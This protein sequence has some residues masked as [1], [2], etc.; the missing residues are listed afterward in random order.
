MKP[1]LQIDE[2]SLPNVYACGDVADT[3]VQTPNAR[4]A[5]KQA[6]Y[7]ADNIV[8]AIQGQEPSNFYTP[9]WADAGIKLTLGLV[10][11]FLDLSTMAIY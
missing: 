8:L 1:S 6:Q 2:P 4:S 7:V 9:E 11:G 5:M 10:R 3:G